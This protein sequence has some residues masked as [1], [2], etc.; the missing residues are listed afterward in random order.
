MK[1]FVIVIIVV[2]L[3]GGIVFWYANSHKGAVLQ[4]TIQSI[5]SVLKLD[6]LDDDTREQFGV[7]QDI[8]NM[9]LMQ[10]DITRKYLM[11]LQNNLELRPG[12]GFLGQYAVIEV[13]NGEIL[14]YSVEDT[15]NLD[16]TYKS[17][18]L[19]PENLQKYLSD[20][21]KMKMRDSNYSPHFPTNVADA[22]HF[23]ELSG[24]DA[25]FDG[26]FAI[27]ASIF[28]DVLAVTGPIS[29][30]TKDYEKYGEFTSDGGLM[31]LQRIVEEPVFRAD[32]RKACEKVLKKADIPENDDRWEDCQ[33]DEDG[34]KMK[35]MTHGER[36]ARK[37]IIDVIAKEIVPKLVK[38]D[39]IE[40]MINMVTKNLNQKD[41]QLW[42]R[43]EVVQKVAKD[44]NW[45]GEVDEGWDGDYV[46]I[47]DANVG[48]LKSDYYMKR[49]M[50]YKVDFTGKSAEANDANA[51]RMVRY[52]GEDIKEQ[53]MGGTFV[54]NKPLATARMIYE[55]TATEPSYFNM[56][57][58]SLTRLYVPNGSKWYVRE[59]FEPPGAEQGVFGDKQ[60]YTYKFD[61]LL[62]DTIPTMLQYTLPDAITEDGYKLKIQKQSGIG[63]IPLKVIVI[64][65][66]GK[67]HTKEV[68]FEHD[69]VFELQ[70]VE[71][72]K[73]LVVVE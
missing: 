18:R 7:I 33:Y 71:T 22:L 42:F 72:G 62:G 12:G 16:N 52:I 54:T 37:Y 65:S 5:D 11:L 30:T 6:Q 58:H 13:K 57:Y 70:D 34:K 1:T 73:E 53:V 29:V 48:A 3:I 51:G 25:N 56:D 59:W 41:I 17:D 28:E 68:D 63:N 21:K 32:E 9:M 14:S 66:D 46:M 4:K 35:K 27:N 38:L 39:K 26:V 23:Y 19:L 24:N 49:A 36:A 15:N 61:V 64:T 55:N 43:D 31:K 8:A 2:A 47:S 44:A 10:D 67:V 60:V 45:A 69:M 20:T 50:E 40:P